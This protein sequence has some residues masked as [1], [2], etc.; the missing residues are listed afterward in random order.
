MTLSPGVL[1]A[2]SL[3]GPLTV[4]V[5]LA[6]WRPP[7]ARR[8]AGLVIASAWCLV[9]LTAVNVLAQSRGWWA[10]DVDGGTLAGIPVDG[11]VGWV[12][13]WAVIPALA[14]PRLPLPMVV[15]IAVWLDVLLMP[16]GAPVVVLH[17]GW[18]TGEGVA[19]A[20]ALA[21]ALLLA[22]WTA[23]QQ[24]LHLRAGLQVVCFTVLSLWFFPLLAFEEVG[25]D[26]GALWTRP[27]WRLGLELQAVACAGLM[28]VSAVQ[29]FVTRGQGTP[30]PY[31]PPQR[32][33][34]SGAYA[35]VRNPMQLSMVTTLAVWSA[36]LQ[37]AWVLAA[38]GI[39]VA[40]SLGIA[41][42]DEHEDLTARYGDA[43]Q[44]YRRNVRA[45]WPRWRPHVT[46]P[47][48]LYFAAGCGPCESLAGWL[49]SLSPVGLELVDA[50]RFPGRRLDRITYVC[51]DHEDE[52]IGAL[53]RALEHVN[54]AC[55]F[56]SFGV[57]LPGVR[58]FVQLLV[59][60]SG[61]QPRYAPAPP[62]ALEGSGVEAPLDGAAS[63]ERGP[64][65]S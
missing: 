17:D 15:A 5:A 6:M 36:V 47:A 31:D 10:F 13:L 23:E 59:D 8:R 58:S 49:A 2:L 11:L 56:A 29:E 60:A 22:R 48:R 26:F 39:A 51:G 46:Q 52:G 30:V 41:A 42:W 35:Y 54:L 62:A 3:F 38:S 37:D 57:R 4:A 64:H 18:L 16:H 34:T 33:V 25:G 32:L 19:A 45:W 50:Q 27:R 12:A 44:G 20:V 55:A 28:G 21:P 43:W 14:F 1:R 40:Y 7:D 9:A 53:A 63:A 24:R 65:G 61:G